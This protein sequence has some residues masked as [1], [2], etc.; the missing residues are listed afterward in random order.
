ML[1]YAFKRVLTS[2][3]LLLGV[4]IVVF[5]IT[6]IL[7]GDPARTIAGPLATAEEVERIRESFG[8]NEPLLN[9]YVDYMGDLLQ[10]NLGMSLRTRGPVSFEIF[11]RLPNTLALILIGLLAATILGIPIGV[12]AAT[13]RYTLIDYFTTFFSLFGISMPVFWSGLLMI[14]LFAVIL[15][16]L[17]AGGYG[18]PKHY[19]LPSFTLTFYNLANIMR[20]TRS[21]MLEILGQDYIQTARSKGLRNKVV[22]YKHG[23]RNAV[24]PIVT[25]IG[26]QFGAL[27]GGTVLTETVF[28]W[29]G[30][31]RLMVQSIFSRDYTVLQSTILVFAIIIICTNLLVDLSYTL[32]NPKIRYR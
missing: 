17:P 21:S 25:L 28:A 29:P 4:T 5:I 31:G 23:L 12:L 16:W 2:I 6:R 30:I 11:S 15:Q 20:V 10:G 32:I 7:P 24:I 1:N 9:Q 19:I 14:F 13:K 18:S 22:I 8:L 3:P 26:L 27:L